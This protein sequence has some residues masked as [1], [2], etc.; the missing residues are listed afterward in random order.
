M[1]YLDKLMVITPGV[2]G[3]GLLTAVA[4]I[5]YFPMLQNQVLQRAGLMVT[6]AVVSTGAVVV[7]IIARPTHGST[8]GQVVL[9]TISVPAAA[10]VG[11]TYYKDFADNL[12]VIQ[13]GYELVFSV[14]TAAAGGGAAGAVLSMALLDLDP[15]TPLNQSKLVASA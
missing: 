5:Q 6:T 1:S 3:P 7:N 2:A 13:A 10:V 15:E 11:S 12:T 9:G 8:T 14:L 4:D